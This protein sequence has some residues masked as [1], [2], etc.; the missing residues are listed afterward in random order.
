MFKLQFDEV[1]CKYEYN[2]IYPF[3]LKTK[4]AVFYEID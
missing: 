3:I 4:S 1:R 2:N